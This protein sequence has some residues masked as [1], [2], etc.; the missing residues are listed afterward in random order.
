MTLGDA[1]TAQKNP[2]LV[3]RIAALIEE[4]GIDPDDIARIDKIST[5]EGFYKDAEGNA[6]TVQMAG[7]QL[8]PKWESGP[9]WPVVQP[10]P[11]VRLARLPKAGKPSVSGNPWKTAVVLPDVQ[12]GYYRD[13]K[14]R[15]HPTHDEAAL[16]VALDITRAAKPDRVILVGDNLDFPELGK[17]RRT[18]SFQR[19]TQASID[20]ATTFAAELRAAAPGAEI[21]WI[22]GNHEE[23]LPNYIIDNA[24]AAFGLKRGNT[25]DSWPVLSVPALCRFDDHD[26]SFHPGYPVGEVWINDRLRVIHGHKVKSN[27]STAPGYLDAERVSTI[28]GHVHRREWAERT[29]HTRKG[30]RT[31][32]A[33]SPGCLCRIDGKVP[34]T[35]TGTDLDGV[36]LEATQ[37]WQ[38]GLAVVEFQAGDRPFVYEQV[39]IFDGWAMWRGRE[40]GGRG[41]GASERAA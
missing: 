24:S 2:S 25:P 30:A 29:R 12:I 31:I 33:A 37:N 22:A 20:R 8:S 3:G 6:Q 5:W 1:L 21:D 13:A 41:R 28:Y 26:I 16:A 36:P 15:L 39:S 40:F 23:R 17:Y 32:L 38:Q 18:P 10:G 14:D 35:H 4:S 19:T 34:G 7:V 11:V 27:G 9:E